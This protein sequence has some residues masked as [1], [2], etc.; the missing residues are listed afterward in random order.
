MNLSLNLVE[1]VPLITELNVAGTD[2]D[3]EAPLAIIVFITARGLLGDVPVAS[4]KSS[5]SIRTG[6]RVPTIFTTVPAGGGTTN[7][8]YPPSFVLTFTGSDCDL[9]NIKAVP[10]LRL[11]YKI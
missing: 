2:T 10:S 3:P 5:A 8:K 11:L 9:V 6:S 1:T 4:S 7:N